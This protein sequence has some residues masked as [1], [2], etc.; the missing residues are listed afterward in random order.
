MFPSLKLTMYWMNLFV[1][2]SIKH[3]FKANLKTI[4]KEI[5]HHIGHHVKIIIIAPPPV[6][7]ESRLRYQIERY[8]PKATG[9]L[10]RTLELSG[11]YAKAAV[12]VASELNVAHLNLWKEMQSACPGRGQTWSKYLSD[13]LHLSRQGNV[14]VGERLADVIKNE[15]AELAVTPCPHTSYTGNSSSHCPAMEQM[16]PWHDHINHTNPGASFKNKRRRGAW[17]EVV[18]RLDGLQ[19]SFYRS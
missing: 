16:G 17:R 9:K 8:G 5:H 1:S 2:K 19:L 15:Y 12:E 4:V 6:H 14:F 3:R 13:G 18:C 7:H 10:E 11:K